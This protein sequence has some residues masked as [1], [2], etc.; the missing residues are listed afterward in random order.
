VLIFTASVGAGH[1]AT[2]R[3]LAEELRAAGHV[4]IIDDGLQA[5]GKLT[6]FLM[7]DFYAW[8]LEHAPWLYDAIFRC[9]STRPASKTARWFTGK[10][11]GRHVLKLIEQAQPDVI[12]STYPLV[13]AALGRLIRAGRVH[14]PVI[15]TISDFGAHPMW[16]T[17][18]ADLHLVPAQCSADLVARE[19]GRVRV[20]TFPINPQFRGLPCRSEARARLGLPAG[21]VI[22]LIVGG[23]W[24]VGDL[25]GAA[26]CA[27]NAGASPVIVAGRNEP[28]KQRLDARFGDNPNVRVLGWTAE[29]P[30]L[31]AAA[32][33][34]VQNAGG[35]TCLEA[36][37][38]GLPIVIYRPLPGHGQMNARLM[39]QSGAAVR[40]DSADEFAALLKRAAQGD[41]TA[42]PAPRRDPGCL[43]TPT[44]LGTKAQPRP[45]P[46][47][48][49]SRLT[50][51]PAVFF[52]T[53]I[54]LFWM[55]FS[56]WPV[57]LASDRVPL[58]V[59]GS[60]TPAGTAAVVIRTYD[61]ETAAAL[62]HYIEANHLDVAIFVTSA[63]A[64]GL[65]PT[66]TVTIGITEEPRTSRVPHPMRAWEEPRDTSSTIRELT[67]SDPVYFLPR[68]GNPDTIDFALKPRST[69]IIWPNNVDSESVGPGVLLVETDGRTPD[70]AIAALTEELNEVRAA[71]LTLVG[72]GA[73][74]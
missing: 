49:Q 48:M 24:G 66:S 38:V 73:A 13:T 18:E 39:A 64:K 28:L 31:M 2:G 19:G 5:M 67:G 4:V 58:P 10:R 60:Q 15:A 57:T 45:A 55:L 1:E 52:A 36:M 25:E 30:A 59:V 65:S 56:T 11:H 70:Q 53:L 14:Q 26:E 27:V 61:P 63:A 43:A 8:Q 12:I 20:T 35:V 74:T 33:C 21:A 62:E 50:S 29:M 42:L 71:G 54:M 44:I 16:M 40:V 72:L 32:D 3:E 9:S 34:L 69:V 7:V 51:R 47:T 23:A 6:S 37:Q 41:Q 17:P 68:K 22:P 46:A